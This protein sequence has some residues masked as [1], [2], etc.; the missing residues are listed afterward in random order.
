MITS[1]VRAT[2]RT[3]LKAEDTARAK[4]TKDLVLRTKPFSAVLGR[5]KVEKKD[6]NCAD[7][8]EIVKWS[9]NQVR[10]TAGMPRV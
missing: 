4:L 10:R 5:S 7:A 9:V 3:P 2:L 1:L 6:W 8:C